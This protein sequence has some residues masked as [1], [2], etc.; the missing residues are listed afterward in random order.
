MRQEP[1]ESLAHYSA[2]FRTA[3]DE[4][5][6]AGELRG[7]SEE[8]LVHHL[9]QGM[10]EQDELAARLTGLLRDTDGLIAKA[11]SLEHMADIL[12]WNEQRQMAGKQV[13]AH[14]SATGSD[15]GGRRAKGR[16]G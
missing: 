5:G 13:Y 6:R 1:G 16:R 14:G 8:A 9:L 2:R 4:L 3:A 12:V 7:T 15:R 11:A 10:H